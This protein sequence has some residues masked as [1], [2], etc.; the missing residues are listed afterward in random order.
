MTESEWL[1]CSDPT[2]MLEFIRVKVCERKLRLFACICTRRV[3]NL[4]YDKHSQKA[5]TLVEMYADA[6]DSE[7]LLD[8]ARRL[9][10][11]AVHTA[12]REGRTVAGVELVSMLCREDISRATSAV[13]LAARCEANLIDQHGLNAIKQKQGLLLREILGNPFRPITINPSWL[14]PTVL[15]LAQSA[16]DERILPSGELDP[17]RLAVLSDALEEAGCNNADILAHCR[18]P[19]DH[20]R[21]CWVVD[22]ILGKE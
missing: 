21:G 20:V 11:Q 22:L 3:W 13:E 15:T 17:A 4:L 14:T 5:L 8:T 2:P 10:N 7:S 9:A 12:Y 18:E 19:G 6:D 1:E 16:Y